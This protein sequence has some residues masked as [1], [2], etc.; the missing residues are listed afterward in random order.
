[1]RDDGI[2]YSDWVEWLDLPSKEIEAELAMTREYLARKKGW[3]ESA[4]QMKM[5]GGWMLAEAFRQTEGKTCWGAP[6]SPDYLGNP[7][8]PMSSPHK[9]QKWGWAVWRRA[10]QILK[11]YGWSPSRKAMEAALISHAFGQVGKIAIRVAAASLPVMFGGGLEH[12]A[13]RGH[14]RRSTLPG[15]RDARDT[16]INARGWY[17]VRKRWAHDRNVTECIGQ[18]IRLHGYPIEHAEELVVNTM[19]NI[20]PEDDINGC[21]RSPLTGG[22]FQEKICFEFDT[23][24]FPD[25]AGQPSRPWLKREPK[26]MV[27]RIKVYHSDNP[28]CT[29]YHTEHG[30]RSAVKAWKKQITAYKEAVMDQKRLTELI[31]RPDGATTIVSYQASRDCGNCHSET[32]AWGAARGYKNYAPLVEVLKDNRYEARR[33]V[34]YVVTNY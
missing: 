7:I 28:V 11:P 22:R 15:L 30:P 12:D 32:I 5:P 21:I 17:A 23:G 3:I 1:M 2:G 24:F 25:S 29:D 13:T 26:W 33:L 31:D 16:L 10:R 14:N 4:R 18:M 20:H 8:I 34:N 19:F 9:M 27:S 6:Y